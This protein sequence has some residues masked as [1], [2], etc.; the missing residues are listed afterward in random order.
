VLSG[1]LDSERDAAQRS[2]SALLLDAP[3]SPETKIELGGAIGEQIGDA[4]GRLPDVSQSFDAVEPPADSVEQFAALEGDLTA[5]VDKAATHAF[6][7]PFL[8]AGAI[9]ALALIPIYVGKRW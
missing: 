3:L 2:G 4:D 1:Q 6:S 5:E 8:L 7:L 9:A